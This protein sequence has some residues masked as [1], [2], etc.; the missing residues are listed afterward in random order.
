MKI[1]V[2]EDDLLM[3]ETLRVVFSS[4]DL[5]VVNNFSDAVSA[6]KTNNYLAAFLDI[7]LKGEPQNLQAGKYP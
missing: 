4:H 7:Q 5:T 3:Q 6:L 1:L 2:V